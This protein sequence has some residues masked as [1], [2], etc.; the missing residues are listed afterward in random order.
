[1]KPDAIPRGGTIFSQRTSLILILTMGLTF[2]IYGQ[3]ISTYFIA[4]D[5]THLGVYSPGE[6]VQMWF[7]LRTDDE[8]LTKEYRPLAESGYAIQRHLFGGDPEGYHGVSFLLHGLVG[9]MLFQLLRRIGLADI[10]ALAGALFW[11]MHPGLTDIVAWICVQA[12]QW[13][14]LFYLIAVL[15]LMTGVTPEGAPRRSFGATLGGYL[16]FTWLAV[17]S[18]EMGL[19]IPFVVAVLL[20]LPGLT[21]GRRGWRYT[22]RLILTG[23]GFVLFVVYWL[24]RVLLLGG[25]GGYGVQE[26]F[27]LSWSVV[28]NVVQYFAWFAGFMGSQVEVLR[29]FDAYGVAIVAGSV[30]VFAVLPWRYKGA[31]LWSLCAL[32]PVYTILK[33][34]NN[35][36][37]LMGAAWFFGLLIQDIRRIPLPNADRLS[38]AVMLVVVG[39]LTRSVVLRL[40]DF[41]EASA[42]TWSLTEQLRE[43]VPNPAPGTMFFLS[44]LPDK[45]K[46][47]FVM[48]VG[49]FNLVRLAFPD[50]KVYGFLAQRSLLLP[51]YHE[52]GATSARF[53]E[54]QNGTLLPQPER[55]AW[56]REQYLAGNLPATPP[57][58][59]R[60]K[61]VT[62]AAM[63]DGYD[64]TSHGGALKAREVR[65]ID[66]EHVTLTMEVD[67]PHPRDVPVLEVVLTG[68]EMLRP[69]THIR[70]EWF[71][72]DWRPIG[73][74]TSKVAL[75]DDTGKAAIPLYDYLDWYLA[76]DIGAL[77]VRLLAYPGSLE[78]ATLTFQ[79]P[80][81]KKFANPGHFPP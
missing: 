46:G 50:T 17:S 38:G 31:V 13:A 58:T 10:P 27:S 1:M 7:Q 21:W 70:L 8:L 37:P 41:R 25:F 36:I 23:S 14:G 11:L 65:L 2:L 78:T 77:R 18:K 39:L 73:N 60:T 81:R 34:T 69:F 15:W 22:Q 49:V 48:R 57:N 42:M 63:D 52:Y 45:H 74:L 75:R 51:R 12:D 30:L 33:N 68:V 4:A 76:E 20:W 24:V 61:V 54:W 79:V 64:V 3:N 32:I 16:A 26:H 19:T 53:F 59:I 56:F 35:Y 62:L 29:L 67:I 55:D 6:I 66:P 80:P 9:F 28:G 72:T 43:A 71:T 5:Y 44:D 47:V 40:V